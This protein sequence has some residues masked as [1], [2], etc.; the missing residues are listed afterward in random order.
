MGVAMNIPP[1]ALEAGA[2]AIAEKNFFGSDL[3]S[4]RLREHHQV[5]A[6]AAFEAM[7]E[8]WDGAFKN[9]SGD[10]AMLRSADALILPLMEKPNDKA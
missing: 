7:V 6:R 5:L 4:P 3:M 1:A 2:R 9:R 10:Y 8:N